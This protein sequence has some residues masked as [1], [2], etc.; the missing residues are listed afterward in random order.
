MLMDV[1]SFEFFKPR[2]LSKLMA[3]TRQGGPCPGFTIQEINVSPKIPCPYEII[4]MDTSNSF[5]NLK[6]WLNCR[7]CRTKVRRVLIRILKFITKF[8]AYHISFLIL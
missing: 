4:R 8:R 5:W 7:G 1:P 3:P 2:K 6:G